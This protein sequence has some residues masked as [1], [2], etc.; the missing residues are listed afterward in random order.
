MKSKPIKA[1]LFDLGN[2]I[3]RFDPEILVKGYSS[4]TRIKTP[5]FVE[6]VLES[7]NINKYMEGKLT[8]SQFYMRTKRLFKLKIS[9]GDFYK[10]WND[11]FYPYPEMETMLRDIRTKYPNI[12]LVL[13]SNTNETHYDFLEKEYKI[14][15]I[16]DG[17]ILSHEVGRQ[18]P[19]PDIFQKALKAAGSLPKETFYTDDR[20]DLIE[21]ARS[22]G[23]RA[24]QFTG[25][26]ELR[27]ALARLDIHI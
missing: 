2:V 15:D 22:M 13:I 21:A 1:M 3:I 5:N 27:S 16:F 18:K 12:K 7:T 9:Y 24:F 19:H 4:Y 6:Y 14:L 17:V 23:L 25:H 10:V 26:E 20:L 11:I 8:S